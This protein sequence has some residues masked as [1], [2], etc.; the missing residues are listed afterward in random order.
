MQ[1]FMSGGKKWSADGLR[2]TMVQLNFLTLQWCESDMHSTENCASNF[3][4]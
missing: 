1:H 2:L 3:E 4:F